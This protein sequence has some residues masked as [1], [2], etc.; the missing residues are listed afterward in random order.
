M[1]ILYFGFPFFDNLFFTLV[2]V[3]HKRRGTFG[4][5]EINTFLRQLRDFFFNGV[6]RAAEFIFRAALEIQVN[7]NDPDPFGQ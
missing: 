7:R 1:G 5:N 2:A 4:M 3:N 6:E